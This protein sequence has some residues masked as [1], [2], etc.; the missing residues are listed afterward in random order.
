M[1]YKSLRDTSSSYNTAV[2]YNSG[3]AMTS[4]AYNTIIGSFTGYTHGI[5]IRTSSN[6]IVIAIF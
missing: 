6:N 1:G 2:G 3:N 4:G 5:D